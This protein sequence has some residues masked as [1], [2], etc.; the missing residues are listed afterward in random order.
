MPKRC[1]RCGF[2]I[3]SS[4]MSLREMALN[5]I[6]GCMLLSILIPVGLLAEHWV[7]DVGHRLVEHMVWREPVE[8]W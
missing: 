6:C 4:R 2:P 7:E 1:P 5:L 8:R 3:A